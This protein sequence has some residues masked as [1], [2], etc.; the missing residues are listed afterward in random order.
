MDGTG[1]ALG[2]SREGQCVGVGHLPY[3]REAGVSLDS[4]GGLAGVVD[5]S[6]GYNCGS[7]FLHWQFEDVTVAC[8]L[9][10][11]GFSGC[12]RL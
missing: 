10:V 6:I 3:V 2:L 9:V 5:V 7:S 4:Q 12:L 8:N 1:R 11:A